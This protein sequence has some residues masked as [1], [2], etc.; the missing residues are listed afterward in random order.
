MG[1]VARQLRIPQS[2]FFLHS[3]QSSRTRIGQYNPVPRAPS[4]AG[5]YS[6]AHS[7]RTC[8]LF[9]LV[10]SEPR[11][12]YPHFDPIP[13]QLTLQMSSI[14]PPP[15]PA[16]RP[17]TT[18]SSLPREL[19][20]LV[21]SSL[22]Q[23]SLVELSRVS[24]ATT[25]L[26]DERLWRTLYLRL[27]D[28]Y[29]E[30]PLVQPYPDLCTE[31]SD[32]GKSYQEWE[33]QEERAA[34]E[35][36][37]DALRERTNQIIISADKRKLSLVRSIVFNP[38]PGAVRAALTLLDLAS[39]HLESL[40]V[41]GPVDVWQYKR[42]C[43]L[44]YETLDFNLPRSHLRFPALTHVRIGPDTT[45]SGGIYVSICA[46]APNLH[47]LDIECQRI[48][49]GDRCTQTPLSPIRPKRTR[50]RRLR[51]NW[52]LDDVP[53][54]QLQEAF[55]LIVGSSPDLRQLSVSCDDSAIRDVIQAIGRLEKLEDLH[56]TC[57]HTFW[58]EVQDLGGEGFTGLKRLV[59]CTWNDL[60]IVSGQEAV[61]AWQ[62]KSTD[63]RS[64]AIF[65]PFP[66]SKR[67][68]TTHAIR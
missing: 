56:W 16:S 12:V 57:P 22:D 54:G 53:D 5:R 35:R 64:S 19:L 10:S 47:T 18:L 37:R 28:H 63:D 40:E 13:S 45:C 58:E 48:R 24:R 42:D 41:I 11:Q 23:T 50:I 32:R 43:P 44:S 33:A 36:I 51:M 3:L 68:I 30:Q 67:Y 20:V 17:T 55:I 26:A 59:L 6:R 14:I 61:S 62:S 34:E 7:R 27:P 21:S 1:R 4:T 60:E 52:H 29:G 8:I 38:R 39:A 9:G 46:L 49:I 31:D 15:I 25:F 65:P 66:A 2:T